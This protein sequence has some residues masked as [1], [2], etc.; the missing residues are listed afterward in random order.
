[1][2]FLLLKAD[3]LLKPVRKIRIL[4]KNVI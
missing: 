1:M 4:Y 2:V 3:Y